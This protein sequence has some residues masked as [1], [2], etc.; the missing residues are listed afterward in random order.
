MFFGALVTKGA[1]QGGVIG[2]KVIREMKETLG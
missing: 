2:V 1:K